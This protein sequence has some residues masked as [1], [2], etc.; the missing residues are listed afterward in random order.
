M[1]AFAPDIPALL[2]QKLLDE[3]RRKAN[4][5][6][7]TIADCRLLSEEL[8]AKQRL[9]VSD[10]TIARLF[11]VIPNKHRPSLF[12]LDSLAEYVGFGNWQQ[13]ELS[14]KAEME[15]VAFAEKS[16]NTNLIGSDNEML[17]LQSCIEYRAFD[18]VIAYFKRH[19]PALLDYLNDTDTWDLAWNVVSTIGL[20][21]KNDKHARLALIPSIS[22]DENMRKLFFTLWV[23]MQELQSYYADVVENHFLKNISPI[24]PFYAKDELWANTIIMYKHLYASNLNGFL[25][26]GYHLFNAYNPESV[27]E[28]SMPGF[29]PFARFHACHIM[30]RFFSNP[31]TPL[32]WYEKKVD[33]FIREL[34]GY[35]ERAYL[36]G[37]P[38][39]AEALFVAKQYDLMIDA[40]LPFFEK[41]TQNH[42]ID[43]TFEIELSN[44]QRLIFYLHLAF[45]K[46]NRFSITAVKLDNMYS[47][48]TFQLES[49][50]DSNIL[51][52]MNCVVAS[53]YAETPEKKEIL[54]KKA[55]SLIVKLNNRHFSRI[56]N[57]I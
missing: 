8:Q 55:N 20:A 51:K 56:T 52:Y 30:Y 19:A 4:I 1:P 25:K 7:T 5:S 14:H 35:P 15:H 22:R 54:L 29:Y 39:I 32:A 2:L 40:I 33:F 36:I 37:L 50:M 16:A 6:F 53:L 24:L 49:Q 44:F 11:R 31:K 3:V 42:F 27:L 41:Y 45:E 28:E 13:F 12:T 43:K 46:A 38:Q 23:D 9:V 34:N 18:P 17:L 21:I 48:S 57:E 47:A 10:F 26:T